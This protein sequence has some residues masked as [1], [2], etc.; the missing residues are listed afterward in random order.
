MSGSFLTSDLKVCFSHPPII[1]NFGSMTLIFALAAV[2]LEK[3]T[4]PLGFFLGGAH[5]LG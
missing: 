3:V 4:S 2:L 1:L 5:D